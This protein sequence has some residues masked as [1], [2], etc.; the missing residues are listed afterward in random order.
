[1]ISTYLEETVISQCHT[2]CKQNKHFE[3]PSQISGHTNEKILVSVNE[4]FADTVVSNTSL[5][6]ILFVMDSL[7]RK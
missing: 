1:M 2:L 3:N 7:G 6:E 4:Q 5:L